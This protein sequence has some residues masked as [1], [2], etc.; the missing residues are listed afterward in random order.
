MGAS[1]G[2]R[3]STGAAARVLILTE[4]VFSMDGDQAPL[5][6][7][8]E[9]KERYGAWLLVDEAHA[10][11][12]YGARRRG[13]GE[14]L[15]VSE[16]IE[17]QMGTLGKAIG[18]AGGYI[19]GSRVLIDFLINKARPFIFSTA[20]PPAVAAAAAAGIRLIASAEGARRLEQLWQRADELPAAWRT[21]AAPRA[22]I[23]IHVGA[24]ARAVE[25]AARL[26]ELGVF[27]PAIRYPTVARGRARLRLSLTA[28]H[29][30]ADLAE[31]GRAFTVLGLGGEAGGSEQEEGACTP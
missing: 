18:A 2:R 30:A 25:V 21:P 31:L 6:E 14:A 17:I 23:P 1:P 24:E 22:I 4:S 7:L 11:G 29:S 3:P 26:R 16:R 9:L 5:R 19:A 8:V 27:V 12:L 15:G 28:A 10:T 20:P 13:L